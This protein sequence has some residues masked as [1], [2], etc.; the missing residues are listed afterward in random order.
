MFFMLFMFL[1]KKGRY[2]INEILQSWG[3]SLWSSLKEGTAWWCG[4]GSKVY[5]LGPFETC[6]LLPPLLALSPHFP[7]PLQS[8]YQAEWPKHQG[9][10]EGFLQVF[11]ACIPQL[12]HLMEKAHQVVRVLLLLMTQSSH[13]AAQRNRKVSERGRENYHWC[14]PR[15]HLRLATSQDSRCRLAFSSGRK[16]QCAEWCVLLMDRCWFPSSSWFLVALRNRICFDWILYRARG[17]STESPCLR[18]RN[19]SYLCSNCPTMVLP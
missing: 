13:H 9:A 16:L 18:T 4:N 12:C 2:W 5:V 19:S 8:S 10:W 6:I 11:W 3:F 14:S 15:G 17:V 1:L 7:H